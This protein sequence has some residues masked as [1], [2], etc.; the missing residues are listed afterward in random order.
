MSSESSRVWF[1]SGAKREKDKP[2]EAVVKGLKKAVIAASFLI[3]AICTYI[4]LMGNEVFSGS[5]KNDLFSWYFFAKG[6]FCSFALYLLVL[7][8]ERKST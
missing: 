3:F 1:R 8:L 6:I 5:F 7:I 4:F 2:K